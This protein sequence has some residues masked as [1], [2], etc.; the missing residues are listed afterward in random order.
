MKSSE[1]ISIRAAGKRLLLF[2]CIL[3][4]FTFVFPPAEAEAKSASLSDKRLEITTGKSRRLKLQNNKKKA[5]WSIVSGK[6][7]IQLKGKSKNGVT[8]IGKKAGKA[9][10]RAKVGKKKYVCN[11]TVKN[12]KKNRTTP[13]ILT[14]GNKKLKGY[15]YDTEPAKSLIAKLPLTI[16]LDDSDN[17]FCGGNLN[18]KYSKKDV[19]NGYKNGDLAFWTPGRNFVIF[20]DDEEKSADTGDLIILGK[21]TESQKVL[22]SLKGTLKVTITLGRN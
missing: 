13:I 21:L 4:A 6:N 1:F 20:V 2:M 22:D 8:I 18:L 15:L 10:V 5:T 12:A 9:V 14:I 17:D 7:C 11:V 16:T 3:F 19:Q